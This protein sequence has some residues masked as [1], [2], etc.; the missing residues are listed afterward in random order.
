LISA[1]SWL[2]APTGAELTRGFREKSLSSRF[3]TIRNGLAG[4]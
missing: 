1:S 2:E 4:A 3:E